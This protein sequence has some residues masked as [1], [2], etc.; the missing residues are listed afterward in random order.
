MSMESNLYGLWGAKQTAKGSPATVATRRFIQVAGDSNINRDDAS[1]NYSDL[2]RFG[3]STDWVNTVVGNINPGIEATPSET[4][5]LF[6]MF[7]GGET[8]SGATNILHT[9]VPLPGG[10]F[11]A[12]MWQ[13]VGATQIRRHKFND[14]KISSLQLEGSTGNK[15][16]RIT[17]TMLSLDPGEIFTTDPTPGMPSDSR[18]FLYTE[19]ASSYTVDGTVL[20]GQSQFTVT[21]NDNLTPVYGDSTTPVDL[22]P[23]NA[24]IDVAISMVLDAAGLQKYNNLIFGTTSPTLG[25]KPIRSLPATGSWNALLTKDAN[26]TMSV[27]LPGVKWSPDMAMPPNPDGGAIELAMAGAM[28]K[29]SGQAGSTVVV[30][31]LDPTYTN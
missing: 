31:N 27:T 15:A 13:R 12:T 30:K 7:F 14:C 16:C 19:G 8:V 1:E 10:S 20:T 24:S 17:P 28:R 25:A 29:V 5:W 26:T 2:D 3:N 4:A 21:W 6:F 23:G 11:W 18:V 9:S 22:V